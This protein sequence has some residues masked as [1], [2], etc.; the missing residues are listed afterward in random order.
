M[1]KLFVCLLLASACTTAPTLTPTQAAVEAYL[2]KTLD[3]PAIYQPVRWGK[4]TAWRQANADT[5][6]VGHEMAAWQID[7]QHARSYIDSCQDLS[8]FHDLD[9]ATVGQL[10]RSGVG[11]A[12]RADTRL[13]EIR[14]LQA[15]RDT[16]RLGMSV[17]H[18]FRAKNKMGALVLDSARFIVAN[19][20]GVAAI[21]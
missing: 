18:T 2:K 19:D 20:G 4:V 14:R 10:K 16:T 15:S 13:V 8:A 1:K 11:A 6:A 7:A 3:D 17:R 5:L 9:S 21:E 12:T